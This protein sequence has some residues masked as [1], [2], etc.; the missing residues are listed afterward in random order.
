MAQTASVV[1]TKTVPRTSLLRGALNVAAGIL[2][3]RPVVKPVADGSLAPG[4]AAAAA[5]PSWQADR[6]TALRSR[7]S[8]PGVATRMPTRAPMSRAPMPVAEKP[9]PVANPPAADVQA[10]TDAW[11]QD[12]YS[13]SGGGPG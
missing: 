8:R 13:G 6:V 12:Y 7:F 3:S 4:G 2:P 1:P 10:Y 5:A 11:T 9:A